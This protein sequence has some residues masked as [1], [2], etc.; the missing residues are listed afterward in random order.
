MMV[1]VVLS[2]WIFAT[3][4]PLDSAYYFVNPDSAPLS[5]QNVDFDGYNE[6]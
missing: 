2:P 6:N 3:A 1:L 4:C 5:D